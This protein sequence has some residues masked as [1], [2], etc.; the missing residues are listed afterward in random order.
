MRAFGVFGPQKPRPAAPAPATAT[1]AVAPTPVLSPALPS[2]KG[3]AREVGAK[4][5]KAGAKAVD[6]LVMSGVERQFAAG[7]VDWLLQEACGKVAKPAK[8]VAVPEDDSDYDLL[9]RTFR[10]LHK[11]ATTIEPH[12]KEPEHICAR[13]LLKKFGIDTVVQ[14]LKTL[15][16]IDDHF[17]QQQGFTFTV[18]ERHWSRVGTARKQQ[19]R[20][21]GTGTP[22][23]CTHTPRC[24]TISEHTR[25]Y[26]RDA[27]G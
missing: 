16:T 24:R 1:N 8:A 22:A 5:R 20:I 13:R 10:T 9:M 15:A 12:L 23:G 25:R 6:L 2:R 7:L 27:N 19:A 3:P 26:L 17:I 18:L 4:A 11:Q 14:Q 21:E